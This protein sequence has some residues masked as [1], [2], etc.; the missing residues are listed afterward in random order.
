MALGCSCTLLPAPPARLPLLWLRCGWAGWLPANGQQAN[1]NHGR[2]E[3]V[4]ALLDHNA[5]NGPACVVGQEGLTWGRQGR[6][7]VG[8]GHRLFT[9]PMVYS[10]SACSSLQWLICQLEGD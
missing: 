7:S 10:A 1:D 8:G 5:V 9:Q 2:A 3:L 6:L 4:H